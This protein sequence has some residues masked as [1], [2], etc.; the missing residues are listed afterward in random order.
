MTA[1]MLGEQPVF[2]IKTFSF[3]AVY[4]QNNSAY[5]EDFNQ[6]ASSVFTTNFQGLGLPTKLYSI[7]E[8]L[9]YTAGINYNVPITCGNATDGLCSFTGSCAN[10][11]AMLN[12]LTFS[13]TFTDTTSSSNGNYVNIPLQAF[14]YQTGN[15]CVIDVTDLSGAQSQNV[16]FGAQFY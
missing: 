5:F 8:Q 11:S 13:V 15:T 4:I 2:D 1:N 9:L 3:G 6:T 7:Y 10:S 14:A 12:D 16:V